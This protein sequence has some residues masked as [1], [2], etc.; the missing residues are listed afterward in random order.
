VTLDE[1]T[2]QLGGGPFG[3]AAASGSTAIAPAG[4]T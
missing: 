2:A 1:V 4:S 3:S